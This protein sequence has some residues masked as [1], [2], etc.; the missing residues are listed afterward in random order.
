MVEII[1]SIP[2]RASQRDEHS[3]MFIWPFGF[4]TWDLCKTWW[5]REIGRESYELC[6]FLTTSNGICISSLQLKIWLP[7]RNMQEEG[8]TYPADQ[9]GFIHKC[10]CCIIFSW[11]VLRLRPT[12]YS[13]YSYIVVSK[14]FYYFFATQLSRALSSLFISKQPHSNHKWSGWWRDLAARMGPFS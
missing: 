1:I 2:L 6:L 7:R 8:L 13:I 4:H 11:L 12:G 5:E 3:T 14:T 10:L 9:A